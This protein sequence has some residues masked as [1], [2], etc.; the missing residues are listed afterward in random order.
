MIQL[1]R[2]INNFLIYLH[3]CLSSGI[4]AFCFAIAIARESPPIASTRPSD[5][6]SW[7]TQTLPCA[8]SSILSTCQYHTLEFQR[9]HEIIKYIRWY[10]EANTAIDLE[11]AALSRNFL[12]ISCALF[13]KC[14]AS[15][16]L[17]IKY[18]QSLSGWIIPKY[19]VQSSTI[20]RVSELFWAKKSRFYMIELILS[21]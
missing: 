12:Y 6:A 14:S 10:D 20:Q 8:A 17:E 4:F 7:P 2:T 21:I 16:S 9:K 5:T 1:V 19:R 18:T 3:T 15:S 11:K 13:A